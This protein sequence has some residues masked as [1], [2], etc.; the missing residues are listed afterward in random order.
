MHIG[1]T[2]K[3]CIEYCIE[4]GIPSSR[5]DSTPSLKQFATKDYPKLT[6]F[7]DTF[8][9]TKIHLTYYAR[10]NMPFFLDKL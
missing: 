7:R 9:Y 5:V 8:Y 4:L 1:S 6:H 10:S 2:S 3:S